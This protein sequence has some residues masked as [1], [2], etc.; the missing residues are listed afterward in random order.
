MHAGDQSQ[1]TALLH[2]FS[3]FAIMHTYAR[4]VQFVQFWPAL[5]DFG[6]SESMAA[7]AALAE[8]GLN[9]LVFGTTVAHSEAGPDPFLRT[10]FS[11]RRYAHHAAGRSL[12][13]S[14]VCR[15][16]RLRVDSGSFAL[17]RHRRHR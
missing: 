15:S 6:H 1:P 14:P 4:S 2:E 17:S 13:L 3:H 11:W 9:H 16:S 5:S 12:R 7:A 10:R 8:C